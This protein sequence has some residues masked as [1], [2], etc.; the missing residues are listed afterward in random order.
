MEKPI[1]IEPDY[2][3]VLVQWVVFFGFFAILILP[4][5]LYKK[6]ARRFNK[7]GW[8]YFIWGLAV[9]VIG[10]NVVH[11]YARFVTHFTSPTL[12]EVARYSWLLSMYLLGYVFVWAAYNML[13]AYLIKQKN[14]ERSD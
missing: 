14:Q 3:G 5:F 10:L 8:L 13:L 12:S 6:L 9:G 11:L 1:V 2:W 7:K 4:A